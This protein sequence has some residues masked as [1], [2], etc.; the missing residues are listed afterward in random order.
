MHQKVYSKGGSEFQFP[1]FFPCDFR[2][3][4]FEPFPISD[5]SRGES[6]F[7]FPTFFPSDFRVPTFEPIPISD[8]SNFRHH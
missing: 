5:T 4:S 6:E 8:S 1:M 2:V 3:P 7:R